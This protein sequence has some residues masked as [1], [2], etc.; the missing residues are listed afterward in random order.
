VQQGFSLVFLH[1][2]EKEQGEWFMSFPLIRIMPKSAFYFVGTKVHTSNELEASGKGV[3][4]R[5]WKEFTENNMLSTIPN[6]LTND[7][8]AVYTEYE[9]D[10]TGTY[11][12]GIGAQVSSAADAPKELQVIAAPPSDYAV[13]TS[14]S[15]PVHEV[16]AE[17]WAYIWEWS[18]TH[19][20][21]FG[22]DFEVY[23]HLAQNPE[24]AQ[25]QIYV[26]I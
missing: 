19:Q 1:V 2:K 25:V 16:V 24:K 6:R 12:F 7:V 21:A 22:V 15:G 11:T 17:T 5:Q 3:I 18:K 9:S 10:E 8:I 23:S 13:F 20:R 4:S 14:R 26:S